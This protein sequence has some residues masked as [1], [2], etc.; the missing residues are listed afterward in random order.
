MGSCSPQSAY[1]FAGTPYSSCHLQQTHIYRFHTYI[2]ASD[3][4]LVTHRWHAGLLGPTILPEKA[5]PAKASHANALV[6]PEKAGP[7]KASHA[8][9]IAEAWRRLRRQ[10]AIF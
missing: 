7:A 1:A 3:I 10:G 6:M 5:G 4:V 2:Y 9:A 8:N